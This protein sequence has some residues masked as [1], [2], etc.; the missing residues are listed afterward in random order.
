MSDSQVRVLKIAATA[1][2]VLVALG[3]A[4]M[5]AAKGA[6]DPD[7]KDFWLFVLLLLTPP[8]TLAY[9]Y[10]TRDSEEQKLRA[11]VRRA[12]LRARLKSLSEERRNS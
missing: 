2:N 11:E 10:V 3:M 8:L 1:A 9:L 7:E 5:I 4:V 6:P 12:E